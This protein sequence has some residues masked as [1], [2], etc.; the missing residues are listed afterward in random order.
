VNVSAPQVVEPSEDDLRDEVTT[1][2]RD[3][4][5]GGVFEEFLPPGCLIIA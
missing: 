3:A 2:L 1:T 5:D 4:I